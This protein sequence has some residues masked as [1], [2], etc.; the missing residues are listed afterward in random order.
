MKM[1]S[2]LKNDSVFES[3]QMYIKSKNLSIKWIMNETA[4]TIYILRAS[5]GKKN[6]C[7]C[8]KLYR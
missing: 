3:V 6:G 4:E 7:F 2:E 1:C 5:H 8:N